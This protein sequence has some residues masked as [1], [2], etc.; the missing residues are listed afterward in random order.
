MSPLVRRALHL[1]LA[2]W[3]GILAV[4]SWVGWG[5]A[6]LL[7][8]ESGRG[9]L[10]DIIEQSVGGL[11]I[12]TIGPGL[13]GRITLRDLA[14]G[15]ADGPVATIDGIDLHWSP[16]NLFGGTLRIHQLDIQRPVLFRLPASTV[17]QDEQG[18]PLLPPLALRLDRLRVVGGHLEAPVIGQ[19][20]R[21][22]MESDL[23]AQPDGSTAVEFHLRRTDDT[24]AGVAGLVRY[25]LLD[26]TLDVEIGGGEPAGGVLATLLDLPERPAVRLDL[27]GSGPLTAWAGH[28]RA[29]IAG[30]AQATLNL[31]LALGDRL[32]GQLEGQLEGPLDIAALAPPELR[33]LL[34]QRQDLSLN[35]EAD[36][37]GGNLAATLALDTDGLSLDGKVTWP[38][39]Q[40]PLSGQATLGISD[41]DGLRDLLP[42][43]QIDS[44][45]LDMTVQG[46]ATA[47]TLNGQAQRVRYQDMVIEGPAFTATAH[48]SGPWSETGTV[49]ALQ[50]RLHIDHATGGPLASLAPLLA[51]PVQVSLDGSALLGA[52]SLEISNV[53]LGT[54][55]ARLT[56]GLKLDRHSGDLGGSLRLDHIATGDAA[57]DDLMAQGLTG[58]FTLHPLPNDN[59]RLTDI[60]ATT[61]PL[62]LTADVTVSESLSGTYSLS[63]NDLAPLSNLATLPLS[64]MLALNGSLAGRLDNPSTAIAAEGWNL[65]I[66]GQSIPRL[67]LRADAVALT[68][69]PQ[70]RLSMEADGPLGPTSLTLGYVLRTPDHLNLDD[71]NLAVVGWRATG[72][73]NADLDRALATGTLTLDTVDL[74]PT[75]RLADLP[76]AGTASGSL[77]LTPKGGLQK[78]R[79]QLTGRDLASDDLTLSRLE[80]DGQVV[81]IEAAPT[82]D[83]T[84]TARG[85]HKGLLDLDR[86]TLQSAGPPDR[87]AV[88][89]QAEGRTSE[90][91]S[92]TA[93]A[94]VEQAATATRI[95]VLGLEGKAADTP[96][97]LTGP[98][99]LT[100]GEGGTLSDV[101]LTL[102]RGSLN[103]D[104]SHVGDRITARTE[105]RDLP[106]ALAR[107]LPGAPPLAGVL[108]IQGSLDLA[109]GSDRAELTLETR[110]LALRLA[111]GDPLPPVA[112]QASLRLNDNLAEMAA[113][114]TGPMQAPAALRASLPV[115]RPP[116]GGLPQPVETAPVSGTLTWRGDLAEIE[117]LIPISGHRVHGPVDVDLK[118]GGTLA[119]PVIT[120]QGNLINGT[121][122]NLLFGT[123]LEK[124]AVSVNG[125]SSGRLTLEG[126][127]TDGHTGTLRLDGQA[128]LAEGTAPTLRTTAVLSDFKV[129]LRDEADVRG[130]GT[131]ALDLADGGGRVTGALIFDPVEIRLLDRLPASVTTLD[132]IESTGPA[133]PT[134]PPKPPPASPIELD[135]SISLP[136]RTFVRGRGVDSEWQGDIHIGGHAAAAQ[137]SGAIRSVRGQ[138]SALG[139]VFKIDQGR[140]ELDGATPPDPILDF[141]ASTQSKGLTVT[142]RVGGR[143]SKPEITFVSVPPLPQDEVLAQLLFGK[144]AG[145][146]GPAE[147]LSLADAVASLQSGDG[148][149]IDKLRSATGLD[150][151]RASSGTAEPGV[152][153]GK[154]IADGVF[155]GVNQGMAPGSS[156]VT[157]EV[158]VTDSISVESEVGA[159]SA[160]KVGVNWKVDY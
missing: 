26:R 23:V 160:G 95:V 130:G 120:G 66:D 58:A 103:L 61:G 80:L 108:D 123:R 132:V 126:T 3:A 113:T 122:E 146:L 153:A 156:A 37:G 150:V 55:W 134:G 67:S 154:Y 17:S 44:L 15:D 99:T 121:Y 31:K 64:G 89:L 60:S 110:G 109:P 142:L 7:T 52:T 11:S 51:Q 83:A 43:L 102:G 9:A 148:G 93:T 42:G 155:V 19:S 48:P 40:A 63:I 147:A 28:L 119:H 143:A 157:L 10:V 62:S 24:P 50:S 1:G 149:M 137:V 16:L 138:I 139:K 74:A 124:M 91:F 30:T 27:V 98:A 112:L 105:G 36:P 151:L 45:I 59:F 135:V 54:P 5:T 46:P 92:M 14:Y 127:A 88:T 118:F 77:D 86:L 79:L 133:D 116:R 73:L 49:V 94:R 34:G 117:P 69:A 125:D 76:L 90:P 12:G 78:A 65:V 101:R 115:T 20:V 21:F 107:L 104:A 53:D 144:Q 72:S 57:F 128:S 152:T 68:S 131:L 84:L 47:I 70:G 159:S 87:L 32:T 114:L 136:G 100:L 96:L 82:L 106:L 13:P 33:P 22:E 56:G 129:V 111:D 2:A 75:G 25:H 39:P 71:I 35:M 141:A 38:E 85:L 158:D 18:P 4:G 41:P 81:L 29:D 97:G 145:A 6:A 140:I 8:T